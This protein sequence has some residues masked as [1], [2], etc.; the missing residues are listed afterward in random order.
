M[1]VCFFMTVMVADCYLDSQDAVAQLNV[2]ACEC[3]LED[4]FDFDEDEMLTDGIETSSSSLVFQ[5][6]ASKCQTFF[7]RKCSKAWL[8][9]QV[10]RHLPRND[11]ESHK[12]AHTQENLSGVD[13]FHATFFVL[14]NRLLINNISKWQ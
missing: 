6:F 8:V 14:F 13:V 5:V 12:Y 1:M 9:G 4:G 11:V 10:R 2:T 3:F 7:G